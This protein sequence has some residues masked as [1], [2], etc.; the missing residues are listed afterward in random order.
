MGSVCNDLAAVNLRLTFATGS[1]SVS[2][3]SP[4]NAWRVASIMVLSGKE[5]FSCK[6]PPVSEIMTVLI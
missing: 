1:F 2:S 6:P 4:S 5:L 3:K